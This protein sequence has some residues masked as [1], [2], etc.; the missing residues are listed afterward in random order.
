MKIFVDMDGTLNEFT[1]HFINYA[2]QIYQENFSINSKEQ[3]D[4]D[5]TK[6]PCFA[7]MK[8]TAAIRNTIFSTP[9]FWETAPVMK[10]SREVLQQIYNTHDTYI[11]TAPFFPYEDCCKEKIRWMR[12]NYPFFNVKKMIFAN[13][14][15]LLNG[16]DSILFDDR[17]KNIELWGG[18][19]IKMSYAYNS[20]TSAT[21][22]ADGWQDVAEIFSK[23]YRGEK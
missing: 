3:V 8:D 15:F 1:D 20:T 18:K 16:R 21:H 7:G 13:D 10:D 6:H 23:F 17:P 2:N 9:G 4:Y 14:K 5:L 11:L 19:T 12:R 22:A